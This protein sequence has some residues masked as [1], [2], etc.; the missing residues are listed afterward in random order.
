MVVNGVV[1]VEDFM[2]E[3]LLDEI[4]GVVIFVVGGD[5]NIDVFGGRVGIVEGDDGDVDV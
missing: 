4:D 2:G 3:Y 5:G 1:E